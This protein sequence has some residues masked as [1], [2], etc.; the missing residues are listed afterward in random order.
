MRPVYCD[1]LAHSIWAFCQQ[2]NLWITAAH[3]P[4]QL[5]TLADAKLHIFD[6]K[7]EWKLNAQVVQEIVVVVENEPWILLSNSVIPNIVVSLRQTY[8]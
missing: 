4:G 7:T 1:K 3:L 5:N 8:A 2:G 6:D